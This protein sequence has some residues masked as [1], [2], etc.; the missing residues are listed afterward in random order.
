M[1]FNDGSRLGLRDVGNP[2]WP[3]SQRLLNYPDH[4]DDLIAT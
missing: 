4:S 3:N 2:H 1:N